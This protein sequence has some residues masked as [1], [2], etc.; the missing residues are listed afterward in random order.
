MIMKW[1]QS[2]RRPQERAEV[3]QQGAVEKRKDKKETKL[4]DVA[5]E[6]MRKDNQSLEGLIRVGWPNV[7]REK[8]KGKVRSKVW[9]AISGGV[10]TSDV[11]MVE[12][13][14]ERITDA[15]EADPY[16]REM[17]DKDESN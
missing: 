16:Y 13:I 1:I 4:V 9:D 17:F 3:L 14:T 2:I 12:E 7:R 5:H 6:V 10:D 8:F 15:S 11:D